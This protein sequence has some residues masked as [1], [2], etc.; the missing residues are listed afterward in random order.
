M[1]IFDK[2]HRLRLTLFF[3]ALALAMACY[4]SA[5]TNA[6]TWPTIEPVCKPGC[7][8]PQGPPGLRGPQGLPGRDGKDG[9]DGKDGVD[10]KD[11]KDYTKPPR[12]V[13]PYDFGAHGYEFPVHDT[14]WVGSTLYRIAYTP[15]FVPLGVPVALLIDTSTG[16]AEVHVNFRADVGN[17]TFRAV[18]ALEDDGLTFE[19]DHEG[20]VW[21]TPWRSGLPIVDLK[22]ILVTDPRLG[23]IPLF[24][25]R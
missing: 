25:W 21:A 23:R 9:K 19:W 17:V 8:G 11:G 24:R 16:L 4:A 10:G 13:R 2:I 15:L 6:S 3:L 20:A 5:Q 18:D 14:F 22:T 1:T 7:V 12:T